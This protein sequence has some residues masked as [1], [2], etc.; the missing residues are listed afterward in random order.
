MDCNKS[1]F[2]PLAKL[3]SHKLCT[4]RLQDL[5]IDRVTTE[6]NFFEEVRG[7]GG[8]KR[9]EKTLAGGVGGGGGGGGG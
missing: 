1:T 6:R 3:S 9:G 7:G 4:L 2:C 5:T 8:G